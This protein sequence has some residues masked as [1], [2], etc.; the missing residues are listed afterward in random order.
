VEWF[1]RKTSSEGL[2]LGTFDMVA[3][4]FTGNSSSGIIVLGV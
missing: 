3:K 2:L 1:S 4:Y